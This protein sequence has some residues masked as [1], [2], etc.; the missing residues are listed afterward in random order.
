MVYLFVPES[1]R[2]LA[3]QNRPEEACL[4]ANKIA[5]AMGYQGPPLQV[6]EIKHYYHYPHTEN[7]IARDDLEFSEKE[8]KIMMR[9]AINAMKNIKHLYFKEIR[10]KTITLQLVW[11]SLAFG[12]GMTTWINVVLKKI[13]VSNVYLY[14][15]YYALSSTPGNFAATILMDRLGRKF[16]IVMSFIY[17]SLSLLFFSREVA[18]MKDATESTPWSIIFACL[19]H[20]F[21]IISW[22]AVKVMTSESFPTEVRSTGVGLCAASERFVAMLV[23]YVNGSLIDQPATLLII[24]SIAMLIGACF[25]CSLNDTT[26]NPLQDTILSDGMSISEHRGQFQDHGKAEKVNFISE[27]I[28]MVEPTAESENVVRRKSDTTNEDSLASFQRDTQM[29]NLV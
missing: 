8:S 5:D 21:I 25:S 7:S 18:V 19:F 3:L 12:A 24:S 15:L 22:A 2:Y 23:Q 13:Q 29:N 6:E 26:R 11:V 10:M 16:L 14:S 20:T 17:A 27:E 9:K 1:A 4:S 28:E